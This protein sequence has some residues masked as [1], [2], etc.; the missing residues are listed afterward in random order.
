MWAINICALPVKTMYPFCSNSLDGL[1]QIA[2]VSQARIMVES[3][4]L[5]DE[6]PTEPWRG[7]FHRFPTE[8]PASSQELLKEADPQTVLLIFW[9]WGRVALGEIPSLPGRGARG[10]QEHVLAKPSFCMH[11]AQLSRPCNLLYFLPP[12]PADRDSSCNGIPATRA[13][14]VSPGRPLLGL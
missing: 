1:K 8:N 6:W 14:S 11:S 7:S 3:K 12:L 2:P 13:P 4:K 10:S 9:G 5:V